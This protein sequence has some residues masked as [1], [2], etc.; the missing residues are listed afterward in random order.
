M[1]PV[2]D[3]SLAMVEVLSQVKKGKQALTACVVL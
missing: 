3:K 1:T 2:Q